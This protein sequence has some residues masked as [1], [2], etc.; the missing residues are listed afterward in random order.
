[1]IKHCMNSGKRGNRTCF[2]LGRMILN[3]NFPII[4]YNQAWSGI[5]L[6]MNF[7]KICKNSIN[8]ICLIEIF[9]KLMVIAKIIFFIYYVFHHCCSNYYFCNRYK[10]YYIHYE[11]LGDNKHINLFEID[12]T[13]CL[14]SY[15]N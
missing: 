15:Q 10:Y 7:L 12:Q 1:M 2:W 14:N 6:V 8:F 3:R 5:K 9:Y 11:P 13:T 4:R